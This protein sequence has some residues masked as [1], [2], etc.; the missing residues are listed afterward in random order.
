MTTPAYLADTVEVAVSYDLTQELFVSVE[1]NH[2]A[3]QRKN[4]GGRFFRLRPYEQRA[5]R[6]HKALERAYGAWMADNI[7][8]DAS[9]AAERQ[10]GHV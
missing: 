2:L 10:Y 8:A 1:A 6:A 9:V 7:R 5:I 3:I 4:Q